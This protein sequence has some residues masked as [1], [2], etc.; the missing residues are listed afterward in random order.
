MLPYPLNGD[1]GN[2]LMSLYP[3]GVDGDVMFGL[4]EYGDLPHYLPGFVED[5]SKGDLTGW[6]LLTLDKRT[7]VSSEKHDNNIEYYAANAVDENTK[8]CW[9]A[10]TG[11]AG[12][13]I[14]VDLGTVCDIRGIQILW[15]RIDADN[16]RTPIEQYQSYT[17]EVS[18]DNENW[19]LII[20]KSNN[21]QDLR[22]DYI[23]L[24]T[25]VYARYIKLTN[26][27]TPDNGKFAVKALRAF[28]NPNEATFTKVEN[29]TV[30]RDKLDRRKASIV[31]EQVDGAEG[32][33]IRYGI[34]PDRL[35]N[36]YMVYWD[37]YLNIKS[38]NVDPEYYFEVEA[39]SSNTPRYVEN[40]FETR[41]RGAELDLTKVGDRE[42]GIASVTTRIMTY[43]TYGIDEVYVFE[44]ITPGTYRLSHTFGVGIWGPVT[45]TEAELIGTGTEP[46]IEA[47]NLTQF[48]IGSTQW[49]TIE[50]RVYPGEASGRIEVTFHYD[51]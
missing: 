1:R 43:E 6:V 32:Y 11:D 47:L 14:T 42:A 40:T 24:P 34:A 4:E 7:E 51:N 25:S 16:V 21:T 50:V 38:L 29:V 27:F 33:I 45:L 39:F 19:T 46:T 20:D 30:M 23:E 37:N 3:S 31:W 44:D 10:A 8:T 28:G 2:T 26:V 9:A 15:D 5:P 17:V 18:D 36:S 49:G 12:E 41:G 22:S 13:Y 35:Y 48:G